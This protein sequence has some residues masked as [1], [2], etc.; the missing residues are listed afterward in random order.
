MEEV[1]RFIGIPP[2]HDLEDADI[3]PKNSR[4]YDAMSSEVHYFYFME[5]YFFD[6]FFWV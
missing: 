4:T 3:S 1:Y 5:L 6:L 2:Q